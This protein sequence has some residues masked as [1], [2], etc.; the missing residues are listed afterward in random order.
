MYH[1]EDPSEVYIYIYI[2]L[3]KWYHLVD[4]CCSK[5]RYIYHSFGPQVYE[6]PRNFKL[7]PYESLWVKLCPPFLPLRDPGCSHLPM[8]VEERLPSRKETWLAGTS[9]LKLKKKRVLIRY[10]YLVLF[11]KIHEVQTVFLKGP[12]TQWLS[13]HSGATNL[14]IPIHKL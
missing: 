12:K 9:T 10:I 11:R 2:Y 5:C 4:F 6:I 3:P 7:G 14:H 13:E 1:P 8:N